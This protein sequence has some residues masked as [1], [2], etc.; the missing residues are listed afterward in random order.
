[1]VKS[2]EKQNKSK[3]DIAKENRKKNLE[4]ASGGGGIHA[5]KSKDKIAKEKSFV[6]KQKVK[7]A[8]KAP[9]VKEKKD[10]DATQKRES[11]HPI[12]KKKGKDVEI[13]QKPKVKIKAKSRHEIAI[14]KRQDALEKARKEPKVSTPEKHPAHDPDKGG[15]IHRGKP[16]KGKYKKPPKGAQAAEVDRGGKSSGP[17]EKKKLPKI[18]GKAR[19]DAK[20]AKI[21]EDA[22]KPK[23][24][25]AKK[26]AETGTRETS[27][28]DRVK[29]LV[30]K[31][32]SL[33][34]KET[35]DGR[36]EYQV[37][38]NKLKKENKKAWKKMFKGGKL[39]G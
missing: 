9:T 36:S 15:G 16:P 29:A 8:K 5:G 31:K 30:A 13:K 22:R 33:S 27:Y 24:K 20:R 32:A 3:A 34:K 26:Q 1:M 6:A 4:K 12:F 10:L 25:E 21:R 19:E 14:K 28:E 18:S 7:E 39:K 23:K 35:A 17:K 11:T 37:E 2:Y 38:M